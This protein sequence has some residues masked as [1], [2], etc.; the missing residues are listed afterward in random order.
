MVTCVQANAANSVLFT[1]DSF[2]F[3]YAWRIDNYCLETVETDPPECKDLVT[4]YSAL[5]HTLV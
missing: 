2:G 3:I 1:T 5:Q 4:F